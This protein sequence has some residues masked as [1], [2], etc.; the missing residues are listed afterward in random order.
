MDLLKL[1]E[2]GGWDSSLVCRHALMS[3]QFKCLSKIG[4]NGRVTEREAQGRTAAGSLS[5]R[6][7]H[8]VSLAI[9]NEDFMLEYE[10]Y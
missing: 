3:L 6:D 10:G 4:E 1:V 5:S 7:Q 8:Q 9:L 2:L